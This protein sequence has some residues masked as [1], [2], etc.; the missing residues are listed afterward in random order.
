MAIP[1]LRA[2][3]KRF[4]I[5]ALWIVF[6]V[7][8]F[9]RFPLPGFLA[10]FYLILLAGLVG[11]SA[12]GFGSVLISRLVPDS[13]EPLEFAV[14]STVAGFGIFS[15]AMI[16]AGVL[17]LWT[18]NAALALVVIGLL[19][20]WR[21]FRH[22]LRSLAGN[23]SR[24]N[25]RSPTTTSGMTLGVPFFLIAL[26]VVLSLLIAFAPV[27]YYDSLV[28]HFA[29]PQAYIQAGHWIGQ[30]ELIYSAFPQTM[31]MIWTLGMLLAGDVLANL[32]GWMIAMLGLVAVYSFGKRYWG[33]RTALWATALLGVMPAYMLLS[34]GGYVDVGLTVFSFLSFALLCL[35]NQKSNPRILVAAGFFAGC[36]LGVKYTGAIPL[37]IGGL[38]IIARAKGKGLFL[39]VAAALVVFAPWLIKNLYYFGDPV[40][41]FLY[42]YSIH[43]LSPWMGGAAAGYFRGLTEYSP[44]SGWHLLKL[45]WDIGVNGLNLGGGMDVL[46]DLGWAPLFAF[47]P[48]IGLVRKKSPMIFLLLLYSLCFYIPWAMSRPVL[49]FLMP[50]APFLALAAAYGYDQGALSQSRPMRWTAQIFLTLLLISGFHN[51]FEVADTLSLFKVPLGFQSRAQYLSQKLDYFDAAAFIGTLPE[52]SLTY[53]IGDQRGYYYNRPVLVTPVFNTNPLTE[54]ANEASSGKDLMARLK[55]RRVTHLL[56]NNTEFER[57]ENAYHLFPFTAQGQANWDALRF[58]LAKSVYHD[59]HSDVLAL[60]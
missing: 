48:A 47:L 31:E 41:P 54:W 26:G 25:D 55:A 28:Y 40:F 19:L 10:K 14:F 13:L 43:Q 4:L 56:I 7:G 49:R 20:G 50:L 16:L 59:D 32:L 39:Y 60:E 27:T 5:V 57:L 42:H 45:V 23:P 36:A 51:F 15:L 3:I 24:L 11:V 44:R 30:R 9:D 6:S 2:E 18:R 34:S 53:V 37:A 33:S 8:Y 35:W 1:A 22:S 38:M 46:G 58:H 12:Y 52:D 17:G 29:L 21:T